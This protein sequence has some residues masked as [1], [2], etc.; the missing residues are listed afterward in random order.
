M[1][2]DF[3]WVGATDVQFR[4]FREDGLRKKPEEAALPPWFSVDLICLKGEQ[5]PSRWQISDRVSLID[6]DT[7]TRPTSAGSPVPK[8]QAPYPSTVAPLWLQSGKWYRILFEV[9]GDDVSVQLNDG[10]SLRGRCKG[11]DRAKVPSLLL[12]APP[13]KGVEFDN[14]KLWSLR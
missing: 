13:G 6:P 14:L 8:E 5:T 12:E 10:Q 7:K 3:R 1:Q 4:F 9:K 11:A 2:V